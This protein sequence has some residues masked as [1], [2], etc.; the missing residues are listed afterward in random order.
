MRTWN[1]IRLNN[2]KYFLETHPNRS[3]L[4]DYKNCEFKPLILKTITN[5]DEEVIL[6][7]S[8]E[9]LH[10]NL[11]GPVNDALELMEKLWPEQMQQTYKS[12]NLK[13]SGDGPGGKFNGP[14]IKHIIHEET[15]EE[16]ENLLPAEASPFI[17]YLRSIGELHT[18][19][20][21]SKFTEDGWK[22]ALFNFEQNF[23][24]LYEVY[25][26]NMTLK[27]HVILAHY[28]F[29]FEKTGKNFKD[30]NGEFGETLH[31]TLKNFEARKGFTIK[32]RIGDDRAVIT[33]H[34]SISTINA[35][36]MGSFRAKDMTL[37][38]PASSLRSPASSP[39][40]NQAKRF[41]KKQLESVKSY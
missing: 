19:C 5:M 33:G 41:K 17:T 38:S 23:F 34:Q 10:T 30:T 4:K 16:I 21:T 13:K 36:H 9:P 12:N 35:L 7:L 3:K 32:R 31:S 24:Y 27:V 20:I 22:S 39:G 18:I 2:D 14:K 6:T 15:L 1:N 37:R 40:W 28:K 26:I 25:H 29:Y 8:P 11:L